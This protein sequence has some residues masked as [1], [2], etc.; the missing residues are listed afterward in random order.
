MPIK[1]CFSSVL[2]TTGKQLDK[3]HTQRA[4]RQYNE[5]QKVKKEK[6]LCNVTIMALDLLGFSFY[7]SPLVSETVLV[8]FF[9]KILLHLVI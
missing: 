3:N 4:N 8:G 9:P 2:N 1:S 5:K 7:M 6:H